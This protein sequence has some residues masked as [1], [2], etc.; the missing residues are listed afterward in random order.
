MER[1]GQGQ[2]AEARLLRLLDR[3][4]GIN[5]ESLADVPRYV[6]DKECFESMEHGKK[7]SIAAGARAHRARRVI[8]AV[9]LAPSCTSSPAARRWSRFGSPVQDTPFGKA[10]R[11]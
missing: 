9:C 10:V 8:A 3:N 11:W 5:R 4:G 7:T 2:V 1:H 6:V